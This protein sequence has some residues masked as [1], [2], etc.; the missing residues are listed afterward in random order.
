MGR[1]IGVLRTG[2]F[3]RDL[4]TSAGGDRKTGQAWIPTGTSED[5][6]EPQS[7]P[8]PASPFNPVPRPVP[9]Q[10]GG[11]CSKPLIVGCILVILVAPI[12]LLGGIHYLGT[13]PGA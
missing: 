7:P 9:P 6:M 13:Q 10:G 3:V 5:R 2:W 4:S 1:I 8:P 11:G 12:A